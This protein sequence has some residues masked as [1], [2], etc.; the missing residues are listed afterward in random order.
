MKTL[1]RLLL[2]GVSVLLMSCAG[3]LVYA[4]GPYRGKVV[5]A[6]TGQPLVGAVVLAIWYREVPVAPHGPAVDYHDSVEVL[7]DSQGEFVIPAKTHFTA[8]GKI[9]EP[10]F[11]VYYPGYAFY[12]SLQARPQGRDVTLAYEA[13]IFHVEL[14]KLTALRERVQVGDVPPGVAK[15]P[16]ANMPSLVRLFNK[17]RQE[18]GLP[19]VRLGR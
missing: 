13:R 11:V 5:D 1:S 8:I 2:V 16:D 14:F 6:E 17:E 3:H 15:V 7:T 19:P 10:Q 4:S 18:L 12:P 9:R